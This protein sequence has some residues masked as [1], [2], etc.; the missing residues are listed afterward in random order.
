[1]KGGIQQLMRQANQMQNR[2]K[3]LQ[4]ELAE[5]EY[6]GASGGGAVTAKVKG[7]NQLIGLKISEDVLKDDIDM[8][9]DLIITAANEALKK[10]K[11][12]NAAEMEKITGGMNIPGMF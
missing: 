8:L 3:K 7:E 6:E 1:M 12:E 10:A 2:M 9:E 11:D 5:R 4:E